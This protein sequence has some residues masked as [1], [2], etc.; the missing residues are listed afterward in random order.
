MVLSPLFLLGGFFLI[1]ALSMLCLVFWIWMLIDCV[2]R[3]FKKENEKIVWILI[4][5]FAGIIGTFIY[6][7]VVKKEIKNS[8][9]SYHHDKK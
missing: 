9:R 5:I 6:Y 8:T 4:I 3:N 2:Q 1:F 7:F